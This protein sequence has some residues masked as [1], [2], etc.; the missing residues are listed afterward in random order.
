MPAQGEQP[1]IITAQDI[2][3][4]QFFPIGAQFQKPLMRDAER[5]VVGT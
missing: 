4:V 3:A 1:P 5:G 2:A